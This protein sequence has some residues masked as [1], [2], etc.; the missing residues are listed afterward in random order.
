MVFVIA[1]GVLALA[2]MVLNLYERRKKLQHSSDESDT[3]SIANGAAFGN[4]IG[5]AQLNK[6]GVQADE[7]TMREELEPVK[8]KFDD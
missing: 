7:I 8:F 1:F 4:A 2:F 3:Y 5:Q 6:L